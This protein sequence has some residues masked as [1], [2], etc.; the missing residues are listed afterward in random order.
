M[1]QNLDLLL[2]ERFE[3]KLVRTNKGELIFSAPDPQLSKGKSQENMKGQSVSS[4]LALTKTNIY[5]INKKRNFL[6]IDLF[7]INGFLSFKVP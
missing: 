7:L 4:Y 2:K 6:K 1:G 5:I 3:C